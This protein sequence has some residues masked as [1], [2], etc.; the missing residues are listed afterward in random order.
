M[1]QPGHAI[2]G[3]RVGTQLGGGPLAA[4]YTIVGNDGTPVG[5]LRLLLVRLTE[6]RRRFHAAA[7]ILKGLHHPNLVRI[8][9]VVE[10]DGR[11]GVIT[12]HVAGGNLVD[13]IKRCD[14]SAAQVVP[15]FC[16]IAQGVA[17]AHE[18]GLLHRNLKPSKVLVGP[19][20]EPRIA[21]FALGK[22]TLP[23]VESN[24]EVGTTFGTPQYM[25]P[26]QY[27]GVADVDERADL[28]ALGCILYEMLAGKR[29][30]EGSDLLEMYRNVLSGEIDPLPNAVPAGLMGLVAD[31]LDPDRDRRPGSVQ[32]IFDR[33]LDDP[34][35]R[36]HVVL[37]PA[38][39]APPAE[40]DSDL[41]STLQGDPPVIQG[42]EPPPAAV[43]PA[44]APPETARSA[45]RASD[46]PSAP[47]PVP[48]TLTNATVP[49]REKPLATLVPAPPPGEPRRRP[50]G[51][52]QASASVHPR[53][54]GGA[55]SLPPPRTRGAAPSQD[56]L[57]P[58]GRGL[59]VP[60][61][62]PPDDLP[63]EPFPQ[64]ARIA[65]LVSMLAVMAALAT[66]ALAIVVTM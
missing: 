44:P 23:D 61:P 66:V 26:E 62:L 46:P 10:V 63:P 31:L 39:Q 50:R 27:R 43:E 59:V 34:E 15:T 57:M 28:F 42:A 8:F 36:A 12:E 48:P 5:V 24:T 53:R 9:D 49:K 58:Q 52:M 45:P 19:D 51:P 56:F 18:G 17:A 54:R 6:F 35:L 37:A 22:I 65:I 14:G 3:H 2:A 20:G 33:L 1:L 40:P 13:W 16:K 30:F 32:A 41:E 64:W 55:P 11:I 4:T 21:G 25:P 60:R 29:A 38:A 47:P 7:E